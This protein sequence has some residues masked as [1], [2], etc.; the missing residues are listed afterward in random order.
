MQRKALGLGVRRSEI[1]LSHLKVVILRK[2]HIRNNIAL[3]LRTWE[4]EPH[5]LGLN[6]DRVTSPL[7]VSFSSS[8]KW[9]EHTP[10]F[11]GFYCDN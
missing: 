4:L 11:T 10:Y 9:G 7:S 5:C 2:K 8:V 3:W 1:G 6:F